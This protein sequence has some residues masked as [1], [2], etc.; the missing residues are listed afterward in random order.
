MIEAKRTSAYYSYRYAPRVTGRAS[1][2][3]RV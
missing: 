1:R 2:R 3:L